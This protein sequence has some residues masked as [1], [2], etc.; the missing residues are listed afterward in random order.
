MVVVIVVV[1]VV[2]VVVAAVVVV[3]ASGRCD[4]GDGGWRARPAH[5]WA[6]F[7]NIGIRASEW[8]QDGATEWVVECAM[9][10]PG[11]LHVGCSGHVRRRRSARGAG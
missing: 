6:K 8:L 9:A 11:C 10:G 5:Y 2:V 1:E 7:F 3:V 4:G